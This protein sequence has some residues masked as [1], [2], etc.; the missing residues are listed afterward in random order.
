MCVIN[1]F[2]V[3]LKV[4]ALSAVILQRVAT[5]QLPLATRGV[6]TGISSGHF[7]LRDR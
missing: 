6:E 1:D 2:F 3:K 5:L 7:V 4:F